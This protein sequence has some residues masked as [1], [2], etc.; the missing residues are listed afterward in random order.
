MVMKAEVFTD[1]QKFIDNEFDDKELGQAV[2]ARILNDLIDP[3]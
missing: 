3:E 2:F 1:L